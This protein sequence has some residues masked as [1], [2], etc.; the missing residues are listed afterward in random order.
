VPQNNSPAC[1][2]CG[3][4]MAFATWISMPRQTVYRCE[5]CGEQSWVLDPLRAVPAQQQQQPQKNDGE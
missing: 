1:R 3:H 2:H 4:P 5:A